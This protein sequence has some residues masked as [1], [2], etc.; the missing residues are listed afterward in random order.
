MALLAR[1]FLGC[2]HKNMHTL[3]HTEQK[4]ISKS[5]FFEWCH[6][7]ATYVSGLV[8]VPGRSE[9]RPLTQ[10]WEWS[11]QRAQEVEMRAWEQCGIHRPA[12]ENEQKCPER[13]QVSLAPWPHYLRLA[14]ETVGLKEEAAPGRSRWKRLPAV[15]P[16]G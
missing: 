10:A 4:T 6:G 15:W 5:K 2:R 13:S 7:K 9:V 8:P 12:T 1:M 3:S 11:Q 16:R 14:E